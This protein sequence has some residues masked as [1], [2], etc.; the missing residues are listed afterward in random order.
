MPLPR[1]IEQGRPGRG[2][3]PA[4]LPING[5]V[6]GDSLAGASGI[7]TNET[8]AAYLQGLRPADSWDYVSFG[9]LMLAT[10]LNNSSGQ[11]FKQAVHDVRYQ[12]GQRNLVVLWSILHGDCNDTL[13]STNT[14]FD[15]YQSLV[16]LCEGFGWEVCAMD[17]PA[18]TEYNDPVGSPYR[19]PQRSG[20]NTLLLSGDGGSRLPK[21]G[22][23][24][25]ARI[26]LISGL[27]QD[28]VPTSGDPGGTLIQSDG[29][30]LKAAG[31]QACAGYVH[32]TL[33]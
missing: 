17:V 32:T 18:T 12:P 14:I 6:Y 4:A 27:G 29:I 23:A 8:L 2:I 15:R 9:A 1:I 24:Y 26:S 33:G 5:I 21:A 25:H 11:G 16:T 10:A 3:V 22:A 31:Q 28:D 30:H 13:D 20:C 7:A 19:R